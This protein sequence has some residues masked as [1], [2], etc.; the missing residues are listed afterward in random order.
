MKTIRKRIF[1]TNSSSSH[2][3]TV[4]EELIDFD[5][6]II[7]DETGTVTLT[8]G[9]FGWEWERYNDA[10]TKANYIA[11][12]GH[13]EDEEYPYRGF[14][15]DIIK[16]MTGA[17]VVAYNIEGYIDHQSNI[18]ESDYIP[19]I[20]RD[21]IT[22]KK[23]VFSKQAWLFTGNDNGG[24]PHNFYDPP[25]MIYKYQLDI[26][27]LEPKKLQSKPTR[28]EIETIMHRMLSEHELC[29]YNPEGHYDFYGINTIGF[30]GIEGR[31]STER[32]DEGIILLFKTEYT[33]SNTK[34]GIPA[35]VEI[36]GEKEI[37]FSLVK[38]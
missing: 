5:D 7:P 32:Y 8:G 21:R 24:E 23:F 12:A 28:N 9:E 10:L 29:L 1:E 25:G 37:K 35:K 18:F 4:P 19:K 30:N 20:C 11:L 34:D 17:R 31:Y 6:S 16:E 36:K 26:E 33:R 15:A 38:L 27:G 14:L 3:L 13:Q 22:L 2:V